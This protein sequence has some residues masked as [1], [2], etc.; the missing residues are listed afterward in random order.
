MNDS[1]LKELCEKLDAI[2]PAVA[3]KDDKPL[4]VGLDK[5]YEQWQERLRQRFQPEQAG[6]AW[7]WTV[8]SR[9]RCKASRRSQLTSLRL[10]A[11]MMQGMPD[12]KLGEAIG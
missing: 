3:P 7:T 5:K 11:P 2:S 1:S 12:T 8:L 9:R 4:Y 6:T 10:A